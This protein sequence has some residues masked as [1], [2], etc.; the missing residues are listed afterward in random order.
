M[1]HGMESSSA[2]IATERLRQS[3]LLHASLGRKIN[4]ITWPKKVKKEKKV[5]KKKVGRKFVCYR[6]RVDSPYH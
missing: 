2:H 1:S 6:L 5:K 4:R 3:S